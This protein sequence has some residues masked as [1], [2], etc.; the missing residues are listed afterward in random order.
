MIPSISQTGLTGI[1]RGMQ[2]V[3]DAASKIATADRTI[4]VPELTTNLIDLKLGKQQVEV[5][6]KVV[7]VDAELKGAI[8]DIKT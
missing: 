2:Q 4:D 5:S 8:I 1:Q 7:Q 3:T 6:A